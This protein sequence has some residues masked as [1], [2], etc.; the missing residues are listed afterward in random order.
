MNYVPSICVALV[1]SLGVAAPAAAGSITCGGVS[2][3][4]TLGDATLCTQGVSANPN[5]A[6]INSLGGAWTGSWE[7]EGEL[8]AGGTDDLFTATLTSGTFG[9]GDVSGSWAINPLFWTAW[10]KAVISV[11]VGEGGGDPDWWLFLVEPGDLTGPWSYAINSGSGG[12]LS[13]IKLWGSGSSNQQV[14]ANP[15]P[16][17]LMLLGSGLTGLAFH[18]RRRRRTR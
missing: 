7:M 13:N 14:I 9:A 4:F 1:I 18:L 2:R 17:T 8:T 16:A 10:G 11:H 3:S 12:G 15:E 5:G 6:L